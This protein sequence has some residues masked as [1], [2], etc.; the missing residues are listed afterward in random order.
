MKIFKFGGTSVGSPQRMK[1]VFQIIEKEP[2]IILVLS[3]VSG[4]T[5]TLVRLSEL[6]Y[7]KNYTEIK[8][9]LKEFSE[10]YSVFVTELLSK[11]ELVE[12]AHLFVQNKIIEIEQTLTQE[13]FAKD[14]QN[15]ILAQGEII[16]T[17]LFYMLLSEL[18]I[19]S[20]LLSAFDFMKL[21]ENNEPNIEYIND[22]LSPLLNEKTQVFVT[23]GYICL[24]SEN[25]IDNL[26]RGGSDY[27]ATLIGAAIKAEEIQI[28][29]DIDGIHNNDPRIVENTYPLR[30]ISFN[31]AAEMAYFGAKILHP[32]CVFP[33]QKFNVPILLK[34]T[35]RP[36]DAGT[37][38]SSQ[39]S[40]KQI[41]S[42]AVKDNIIA[43][44]IS[45]HRMLM[46]YGYVEKVF[47]I[48]SKYK[49]PIDLISTSETSVS[50][51][52]DNEDNLENIIKEL[53]LLGVVDFYKEAAII[54]VVGN[55][56]RNQSGV[57]L[58]V[59]EAIREFPI[60]M[61]SY[62]GSQNNISFLI[63]SKD[64]KGVLTAFQKNLF[65]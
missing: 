19:K 64:K 37:T 49:T 52:I 8:N 36:E 39:K 59:L 14:D 41:K 48:F 50:M 17:R 1:E 47:S 62:G 56:D 21:N 54:C 2:Q 18:G 23:Q 32:F 10:A 53:E 45:S 25:K 22:K 43:L 27:T 7:E 4:T 57:A 51:T 5:N 24:N 34:N 63:R 38:I 44:R 12:E 28:W 60:L 26:Q 55:F 29:T 42:V 13:D 35:M 65:S 40:D 9:I 31:E 20:E 30:Q 11:K 46:S 58:K 3:A 6:A 16:S 33:A 15:K 61:I